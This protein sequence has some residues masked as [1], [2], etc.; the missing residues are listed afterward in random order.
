MF[1]YFWGL[2]LFPQVSKMEL[3]HE[4]RC[5]PTMA[6]KV[7]SCISAEHGACRCKVSLGN[8]NSRKDRGW[9]PQSRKNPTDTER[10]SK[11]SP[12]S[13]TGP[14]KVAANFPTR[15]VQIPEIH[16]EKERRGG[17]TIPLPAWGWSRLR[18]KPHRS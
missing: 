18:S 12:P 3:R 17:P 6:L 7:C 15:A 4:D 9:R 10:N 14:P 16:P 13:Q 8:P 1:H 11:F 2:P 5:D